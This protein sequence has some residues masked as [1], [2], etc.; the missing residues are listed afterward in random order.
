MRVC[1]ELVDENRGWRWGLSRTQDAGEQ[2]V[3][4]MW[5]FVG[6]FVPQRLFES[7]PFCGRWLIWRL[8]SIF[9]YLP[10]S[11]TYCWSLKSGKPPAIYETLWKMGYSPYQPVQGIFHQ[12]YDT[13][14]WSFGEISVSNEAK[15]RNVDQR[16]SPT[17]QGCSFGI[18]AT[19]RC[20]DEF[21]QSLKDSC[22]SKE[23]RFEA[24][25]CGRIHSG[26]LT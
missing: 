17:N 19:W 1:H 24:E 3:I 12:Q 26:N 21:L 8:G 10:K 2:C 23:A 9:G 15:T 20:W 18:V 7:S 5:I 16:R 11:H 13:N 14:S 25:G 4:C 6:T 22:D